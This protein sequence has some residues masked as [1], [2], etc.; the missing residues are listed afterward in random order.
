MP[1][2]LALLPN[3]HSSPLQGF[4]QNKFHWRCPGRPII[5]TP[6]AGQESPIVTMILNIFMASSYSRL[7]STLKK[8]GFPKNS[9]FT[10]AFRSHMHAMSSESLH[11]I[12]GHGAV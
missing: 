12:L 11:P 8:E 10:L 7:S 6:P 2:P 9:Q 5:P 4:P 3:G 1:M